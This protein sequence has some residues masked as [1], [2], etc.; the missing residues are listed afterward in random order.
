MGH[1]KGIGCQ[2]TKKIERANFS[3]DHKI[4]KNDKEMGNHFKCFPFSY[5]GGE[6]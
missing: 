5:I 3:F 1:R 4:I 2:T 6:K